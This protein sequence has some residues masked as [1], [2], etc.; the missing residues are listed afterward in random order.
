MHARHQDAVIMDLEICIDSVESAIAAERGG[1]KRV[2]LCSDLLEGGITPGAGMIALVRRNI[3]IGLYVMI[4]PRG[5]DFFYTDLE[6]EVMRQE[7]DHARRLGADGLVLGLLDEQGRVD[8]ARTRQLVEFAS[9]LPVTFHR[10]ID[11][12]SD[13]SFA[14]EDVIS[15]GATR[16]LTSGGAPNVQRG[17]PAITR[18]V[19]AAAGRIVIMPGGGINAEN[20]AALA[21]A[22][23]AQEFHSSARSVMPSPVRFRKPGMVLGDLRDRE[24]RRFVVREESVRALLD[25]LSSSHQESQTA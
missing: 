13:L 8:V 20:I 4:R 2:E 25:A 24:Y 21:H 12:T 17:M 5:G 14:L 16:I 22:T 11:M 6:F 15:S 9:P 10:A 18:M 19:E 1:A 7:I 23:S 3:D